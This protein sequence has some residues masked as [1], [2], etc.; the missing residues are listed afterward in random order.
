MRNRFLKIYYSIVIYFFEDD[1][2]FLFDIDSIVYIIYQ[3]TTFFQWPWF[4]WKVWKFLNRDFLSHN[5]SSSLH[6]IPIYD[7][8]FY[9]K[10]RR[11]SF[12]KFGGNHR[13]R[14]SV[15]PKSYK[16]YLLWCK[17]IVSWMATSG[18]HIWSCKLI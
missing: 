2:P 8:S 1:N 15:T 10:A 6:Q 3:I 7:Q 9:Q 14:S 17:W 18:S 4:C 13:Y 12:R 11:P 5:F 16:Y